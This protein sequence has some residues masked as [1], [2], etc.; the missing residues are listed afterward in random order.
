MKKIIVI[1]VAVLL[2]AFAASVIAQTA[3]KVEIRDKNGVLV[4]SNYLSAMSYNGSTN[5][6]LMNL[7][8]AVTLP[9][10]TG[11]LIFRLDGVIVPTSSA[12]IDIKKK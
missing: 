5:L 9:T 2:L 10:G 6:M 1:L 7:R 12:T 3:I 8:D 11:N 4:V